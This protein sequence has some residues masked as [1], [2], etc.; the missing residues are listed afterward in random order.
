MKTNHTTDLMVVVCPLWASLAR[1]CVRFVYYLLELLEKNV[2]NTGMFQNDVKS[3]VCL[4]FL[5]K[6]HTFSQERKSTAKYNK[7]I[8]PPQIEGKHSGCL[9]SFCYYFILTYLKHSRVNPSSYGKLKGA[10]CGFFFYFVVRESLRRSCKISLPQRN[11]NRFYLASL[12][13]FYSSS[14]FLFQP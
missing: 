5:I 4:F 6:N 14:T 3:H 13:R 8:S 1:F 12:R 11:R 9:N 7:H 2:F 10:T